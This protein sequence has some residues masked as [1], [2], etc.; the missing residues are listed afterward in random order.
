MKITDDF[1]IFAATIYGEAANQSEASW[2][3]IAHV[4]TNRVGKREW[5][6]LKTPKAV[7]ERSRFDAFKYKTKNYKLAYQLISTVN[8]ISY[9]SN[10]KVKQLA[11]VVLP[12]YLGTDPDP[13]EE[14]ILYYSPKAQAALHESN[15]ANYKA[16]PNWNFQV[17][18]EVAVAG[19]EKDDFCFYRYRKQSSVSVRVVD[20]LN[21]PLH[22]VTVKI[23]GEGLNHKLVSDT[24]GLVRDVIIDIEN[25]TKSQLDF[26]LVNSLGAA[27]KVGSIQLEKF[28][29]YF[30]TLVSPEAT[31]RSTTSVHQGV[32]AQ[33]LG[34]KA[35]PEFELVEK[36]NEKGHPVVEV[37][38]DIKTLEGETVHGLLFPLPFRPNA[39]YHES[40]RS[41][42]SDRVPGRKHAGIDLYAPVGTS[43]FAMADGRVLVTQEFY[44]QTWDIV[45]DHGN[46]IARYCE[47]S[48][49][50]IKVIAG[51]SVKRGQ[52]LAEV[53]A[54]MMKNKT[55]GKVYQY[56]HSM[57]HLEFYRTTLNAKGKNSLSNKNNPPFQ[58]RLDLMDPTSSIDASIID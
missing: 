9:I 45:V 14:S 53:G 23:K 50:S 40:P 32:K 42:G 5:K 48:K 33:T 49:N 35:K 10:A 1:A 27:F 3:A 12:V 43:V 26:D 13:T 17:L 6:N 54:L 30:V 18:V 47:V 21:R 4:I 19:C 25:F 41:F 31:I 22:N 15:P 2:R 57:L 39:S 34:R 52:K 8:D 55:N 46:F 28:R 37:V 56:K 44:S 29:K 7:I 51:D 11:S 58:R 16:K 20:Q 24:G 38:A 36:R